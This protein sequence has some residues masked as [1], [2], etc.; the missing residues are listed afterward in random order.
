MPGII[1]EDI[2]EEWAIKVFFISILINAR[3]LC[4]Y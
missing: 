2:G 4:F 1:E 3:I